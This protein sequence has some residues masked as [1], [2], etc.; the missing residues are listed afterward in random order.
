M[1]ECYVIGVF[2]PPYGGAT[3]KCKLFCELLNTKIIKT[4]EIDLLQ[5]K[6]NILLC[7]LLILRC[8]KAFISNNP[9]IYSVDTKRLSAMMKIQKIFPKSFSRT[10]V[11]AVGGQFHVLVKKDGN[12]LNTLS[13]CKAVLVEAEGIKRG[14]LEAGV[15]NAQVYPNP[16]S[17]EGACPPSPID[18]KGPI[19][20]VYFSQI[21]EEKGVDDVIEM[22]ILLKKRGVKFRLD[23]YGH[24]VSE[25]RNKFETGISSMPNVRYCGVFD[26]T[27]SNLY[28]HLNQYDILLFPTHYNIEG[29]PGIVVEAKMS[30]IAIIASDRSYNAELIIEKEKEGFLIKKEYGFEMAEIVEKCSNDREMLQEYKCSSY[31]SRKRFSTQEFVNRI[32]I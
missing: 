22:A 20:L 9:I 11:L 13:K 19:N 18:Y 12:L 16:K 4:T 23:F 21:C 2:P 5:G 10:T 15:D 31:I 29:V 14:L 26:S 17:E 24:V 7:P 6:R 32:D 1:K 8:L 27:K 3:V 30:G 28:Q 25:Y